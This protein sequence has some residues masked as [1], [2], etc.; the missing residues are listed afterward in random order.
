MRM[1]LLLSLLLLLFTGCSQVEVNDY[2]NR[3][4]AINPVT[5]FDGRLSAHGAVLNRSGKVTRSF[6]AS[7][8]AYWRDGVGTLEE[9]FAFDDGEQQQRNW[10]LVPDGSGGFTAT[11]GDV[12]G[13]GRMTFSGNA[14]FLDYV[15]RI[16]Y[17]ND[18][19]DLRVD[20]RMYLVEQNVL[21]NESRMS[22]FGFD[23]GRI[24]L[25]ILRHPE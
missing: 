4:P 10:T 18:S 20:D 16:P 2:A 21:I 9:D 5:F 17:G 13:E 22:K 6:S 15:L 1:R 14:I 24:L 7:I 11:A 25:T 23:V 19:I 12:I 3:E 8:K